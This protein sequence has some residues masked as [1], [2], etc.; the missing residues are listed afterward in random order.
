MCEKLYVENGHN[1]DNF[2]L[3]D[4]EM[5]YDKIYCKFKFL[6]WIWLIF[7]MYQVRGEC[8]LVT[9][10]VPRFNTWSSLSGFEA[11]N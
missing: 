11:V 1:V 3:I 7:V 6:N 4:V 9:Y 5:A 10:A 8:I 2:W